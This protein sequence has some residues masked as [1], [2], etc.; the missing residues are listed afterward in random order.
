GIGFPLSLIGSRKSQNISE[1]MIGFG[2]L[3]LG[4]DF[5]KGGVPDLK[6]NPDLFDLLVQLSGYGFGSTMIFVVAGAVI[7]VIVQ[8]SS[9]STAIILTMVAKGWIGLDL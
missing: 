5:L 4:L 3:F 7:T 1:V 8:S 2:L 9:A 6:S